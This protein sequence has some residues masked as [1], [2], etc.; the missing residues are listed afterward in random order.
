MKMK[1]RE[2]KR[3]KKGEKM[4]GGGQSSDKHTPYER[5]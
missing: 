2:M 3:A 5:L 4:D 1:V